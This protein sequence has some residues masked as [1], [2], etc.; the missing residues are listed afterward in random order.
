MSEY[1][2]I[3][4]DMIR[5]CVERAERTAVRDDLNREIVDLDIQIRQLK[6]KAARLV[7]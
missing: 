4:F 3:M 6:W 5:M 2:D 1:E 7:R